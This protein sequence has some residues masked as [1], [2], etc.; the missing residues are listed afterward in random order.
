MTGATVTSF[1]I[2]AD[3][4][5]AEKGKLVVS[6]H[7][8][9]PPTQSASQ[10]MITEMARCG[11]PVCSLLVVPDYHHTGR[12]T[13]SRPF[14]A[15]LR[16]LEAAGHE[17]VIH[18]YFHQR[19]TRP[20]ESLR[21]RVI[22]RSYTSGEGEFYDLDYS[23][24]FRRITQAQAEFVEAGLKPRGF[25]APAWLLSADAERAATEA[26]MEYTTRLTNVLDLRTR[27]VFPARSLVYSVRNGWRRQASLGWN[28]TLARAQASHPLIRLGLHPPDLAQSQIWQQIVRLTKKL[29]QTHTP[30]T[31]QDWI[32][33]QRAQAR[34]PA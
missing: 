3:A 18:G 2:F 31:Y 15:W 28:A 6:V 21:E 30:T 32:A 26:E 12:A 23:E 33:D 17:V 22:T 25:I 20:N 14:V 10:K 11:V 8:V 1:P 16:E 4:P 7:D 24:A 27:A 34:R 29:T 13:E 9:A 5:A 19:P